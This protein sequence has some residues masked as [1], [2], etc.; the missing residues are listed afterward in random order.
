MWLNLF[1]Q[2][3]EKSKAGWY[4]VMGNKWHIIT[5]TRALTGEPPESRAAILTACFTN[6]RTGD[7]KFLITG[8]GGKTAEYK[9]D[10]SIGERQEC[11]PTH[12]STNEEWAA[13]RGKSKG[14]A[15]HYK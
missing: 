4:Y 5:L 12:N 13:Y 11:V 6:K 15:P 1:L 8:Y 7:R 9:C 10:A 14:F 2:Y 3:E